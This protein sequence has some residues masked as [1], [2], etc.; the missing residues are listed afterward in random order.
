MRG[1]PTIFKEDKKMF[2][3]F[4]KRLFAN[5]AAKWESKYKLLYSKAGDCEDT[6][7]RVELLKKAEMYFN[8]YIDNSYRALGYVKDAR[9]RNEAYE[10]L[11]N[12]KK[13]HNIEKYLNK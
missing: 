5:K 11:D 7:K 13:L 1:N 9:L 3:K 10:A 2:R 6:H 8:K 4:K 12:I